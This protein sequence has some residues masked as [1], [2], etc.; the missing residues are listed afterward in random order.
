[1]L[2]V[3]QCTNLALHILCPHI[4]LHLGKQLRRRHDILVPLPALRLNDKAIR[5]KPDPLSIALAIIPHLMDG[6]PSLDTLFNPIRSFLHTYWLLIEWLVLIL[7]SVELAISLFHEV[8]EARGG[9]DKVAEW[10]TC[11]C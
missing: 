7:G 10:L 9:R 1:M 11:P 4:R 8:L 2:L 5:H 3:L 6:Y